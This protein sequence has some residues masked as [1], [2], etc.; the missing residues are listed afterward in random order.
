MKANHGA[1]YFYTLLGLINHSRPRQG[2]KQT[3]N[4]IVPNSVNMEKHNTNKLE[5]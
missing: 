2:G 1:V 3:P 5:A 4:F